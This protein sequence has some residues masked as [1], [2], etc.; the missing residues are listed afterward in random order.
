MSLYSQNA[1]L[2]TENHRLYFGRD[3]L[4][5]REN[6]SASWFLPVG[7]ICHKEENK[8]R[9]SSSGWTKV[10]ARQVYVDNADDTGATFSIL[11]SGNV[12]KTVNL[13]SSFRIDGVIYTVDS[14]T[15]S[16]NRICIHLVRSAPMEVA[17]PGYRMR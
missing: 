14:L 17:R 6:D 10:I 8:Q 3:D 4:E 9:K 12:T 16:S 7:A 15:K 11:V 13:K 1:D 2:A 5:F